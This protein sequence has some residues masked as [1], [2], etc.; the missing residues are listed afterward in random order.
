MARAGL[1][2]IKRRREYWHTAGRS[3]NLFKSLIRAHLRHISAT[4]SLRYRVVLEG[5]LRVLS[6]SVVISR[7]R[8]RGVWIQVAQPKLPLELQRGAISLH[9]LLA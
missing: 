2:I 7:G 3:E 1:L 9:P 4:T 6:E 8:R 5:G